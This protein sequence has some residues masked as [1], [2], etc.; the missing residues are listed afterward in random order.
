MSEIVDKIKAHPQFSE[1][2]FLFAVLLIVGAV[3]ISIEGMV[4]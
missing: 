4:E 1:A 2:A 3:K